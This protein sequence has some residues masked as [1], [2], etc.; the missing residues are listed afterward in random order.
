M[1]YL[2]ST[3]V[4]KWCLNLYLLPKTKRLRNYLHFCLSLELI[5]ICL[6]HKS[7]KTTNDSTSSILL[8]SCFFCGVMKYHP[9]E[10]IWYVALAPYEWNC[11]IYRYVFCFLM[12]SCL[13]ISSLKSLN[14][15]TILFTKLL[16]VSWT[17]L[18]KDSNHPFCFWNSGFCK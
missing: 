11:C 15:S 9:I 2:Y 1:C 10:H 17:F 3:N 7:V 8:K 5:E 4:D 14:F 6:S 16:W 13:S 12:S 18:V